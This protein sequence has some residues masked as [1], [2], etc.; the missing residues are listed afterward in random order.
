MD[1]GKYLGNTFLKVEDIKAS[2]PVRLKIADVAEGR[3]NKPDLHF[4]DGTI[5][6]LN[7]TNGRTLT[8][9][10][11]AESDDWVGKQVELSLGEIQYQGKPQEAVLVKPVSPPIENKAPAKAS[12][13]RDF[14]DDV[15]FS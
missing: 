2:G 8:R 5:L 1:M 3:F 7:A 13:K 10:Y 9:A 4:D 15:P 12:P 11:G 14:N 6:S